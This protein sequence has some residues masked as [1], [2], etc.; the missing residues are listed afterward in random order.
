MMTTSRNSSGEAAIGGRFKSFY[1]VIL[2][3]KGGM[4]PV[5]DLSGLDS[6]VSYH[7]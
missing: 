3:T 1:Q 4:E 6:G 5:F 7:F 2:L